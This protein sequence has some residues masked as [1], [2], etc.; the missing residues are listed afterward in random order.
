[1]TQASPNGW[2]SLAAVQAIRPI[3]ERNRFRAD[4]DARM[5][6]E[7]L[8]ATRQAGVYT[9]VSPKEVGGAEVSF[10]ELMAVFEELGYSDPTV[11]W[12]AGNSYSL[13]G[14]W[15][16]YLEASIRDEIFSGAAGPFGFA[17]VPQGRATPVA[18]G[19]RLTGTWPFMTGALD[20]PWSALTG[21]V[22]DDDAPPAEGAMPDLRSFIVPAS[23]I[24][25]GDNWT[26]ASAMRGTGSHAIT[27]TDAF[28]PNGRAM[29]LLGVP[30]A[31]RLD[32]LIS[33]T[34]L[35]A[36]S[37]VTNAAITAGLARRALD[38]ATRTVAE[39]VSR[40]DGS[41]YRDV[42]SM[43]RLIAHSHTS[44]EVMNAGLQAMAEDVWQHTVDGAMD[45]RVVGRMWSTM[46]WAL[47]E[48]RRVASDLMTLATSSVYGSRNPIETAL[49][50]IHAICASMESVRPTQEAAGRVLL[51]LPPAVP[52]FF[53]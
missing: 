52:P 13:A 21:I 8:E 39:K 43:Q 37:P 50:D 1:M 48:S 44:V 2:T 18:G 28:V 17:G 31:K 46:M 12:H 49:R 30:P 11:A 24:Q 41:R 42:V 4:E 25:P 33:R 10:P 22:V 9:L 51:G 26:Q 23:D 20:A 36:H 16:C 27:V 15:A 5:A 7:V 32:P 38:E 3:L 40:F 45:Q 29:P 14:R 34:P 6:P 35:G 19:F 53:V 47:D